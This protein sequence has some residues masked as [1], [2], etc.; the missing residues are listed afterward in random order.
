L[1]GLIGPHEGRE[2]ALLQS[3]SK[4]V[5]WFSEVEFSPEAEA[6]PLI[7]LGKLRREEW[8]G[9]SR[10]AVGVV[11]YI[12]GAEAEAAE[13]KRLTVDWLESGVDADS[14]DSRIGEILGYSREDIDAFIK[15][16]RR[17]SAG[18]EMSE[19]RARLDAARR[20]P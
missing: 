12:P 1:A 11:Y 2:I 8:R 10:E 19:I 13:L 17:H 20:R 5:A 3:G 16:K 7:A 4:R 18:P 6:A 15:N 9:S 14:A